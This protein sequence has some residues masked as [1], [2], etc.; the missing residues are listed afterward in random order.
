LSFEIFLGKEM[1]LLANLN[2]KLRGNSEGFLSW[3]VK[4]QEMKLKH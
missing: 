2:V 4:G 3:A 1:K